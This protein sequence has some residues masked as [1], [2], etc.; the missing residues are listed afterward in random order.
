MFTTTIC[1]IDPESYNV[2]KY[3]CKLSPKKF[4]NQDLISEFFKN[5]DRKD[6]YEKCYAIGVE[7]INKA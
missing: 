7:N 5:W 6:K 1:V 3:V 2:S 4:T